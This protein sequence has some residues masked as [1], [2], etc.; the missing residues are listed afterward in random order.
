MLLLAEV[1]TKH[2]I[3][4]RAASNA[5]FLA[6]DMTVRLNSENFAC[7]TPHPTWIPP[8][9]HASFNHIMLLPES[10]PARNVTVLTAR[11][12]L[13]AFSLRASQFV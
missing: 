3:L 12:P 5:E 7:H 8:Q 4:A 11:L 1:P 10:E 2:G 9:Q 13:C 6:P